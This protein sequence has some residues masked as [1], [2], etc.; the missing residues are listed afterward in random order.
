MRNTKIM[1]ILNVTPDSFFD[2]GKYRDLDSALKRAQSMVRDGVDI[3]DVGG[4]STRPG[5]SPVE[6]QEEMDRVCP[7]IEAIAS[8]LDVKISVDTWKSGVAREAVRLGASMVNDISGLTFDRDMVSI[9]AESGV[10][11]VL[12]HTGGK[13]RDMQ[14]NLV[15]GDEVQD[16][17]DFLQE[18]VKLALENG[19]HRDRIILD[20]GIGFG[21][22]LEHNY[23]L[24]ARLESFKSLG[25]PILIGLSRKSMIGRLYGEEEDRLPGTIALNSIAAYLGAEYIRVHDVKEHK[26][27]LGAIDFF[28][29]MSSD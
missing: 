17:L 18:S 28:K 21:K 27:A 14:E 15:Y 6:E 5:A 29:R 10:D 1:G 25:F 16:V 4:E 26:L 3:I 7:V 9:V 13:P 20:P 11:V 19:V 12:M 23:V 8:T 2:G 22:S 24:I